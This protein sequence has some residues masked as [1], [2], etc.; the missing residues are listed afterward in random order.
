MKFHNPITFVKYGWKQISTLIGI[1]LLIWFI[2]CFRHDFHTLISNILTSTD[3][4]K[5]I[6]SGLGLI[7]SGIG[8]T[9]MVIINKFKGKDNVDN[10]AQ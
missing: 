7:I 9:F 8:G 10:S 5:S 2:F 6:V 1:C 4:V 3:L